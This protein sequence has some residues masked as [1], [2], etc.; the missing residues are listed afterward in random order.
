MRSRIPATLCA[1]ALVVAACSAQPSPTTLPPSSTS[2]T[3]TLTTPS[4]TTTPLPEVLVAEVS[5][6]VDAPITSLNPFSDD[7]GRFVPGNLVW[8]VVYDID[9]ATWTKV[10]DVVVALPSRSGG[11][12]VNDD[13]TMTVRYEIVDG[14]VWSDGVPITGDD[15]AFTAEV[16]RDLAERGVGTVDPVMATLLEATAEGRVATLTF[17]EPTLVVEDALWVVV[18]SHA[19][20]GA[21]P[22]ETLDAAAW[23]S[24]G[25]FVVDGFE[26]AGGVRF[27]RNEAYWK[28]D[29][30]GR[31]LPYLEAVT[32]EAPDP[33][34]P[35][36][37]VPGFV[38]RD[39]DVASV[40]PTAGDVDRMADAVARG[41]V[42]HRVRTPIIEQLTFDFSDERFTVNPNSVNEFVEFRRAVAG[43]IDPVRLL[44]DADVPWLPEA[45]GLLVPVGESAWS[46]Y[47]N[48][49]SARPELP[50]GA[51]TVLTTTGNAAERPRI[52]EALASVFAE[53]GV[54]YASRL[55]DSQVFF[56]QTLVEGT[57]DLGLWAWVAADGTYRGRLGL[58]ERLDPATSPPAGNYGRWGSGATDTEGARRFSE[59][60]AEARST[61]D[62]DRFDEL[63]HEAEAILATELPLIPLFSRGSGLAVW[64]DRITGVVH[65]GSRS[66]FTWNVER[67]RKG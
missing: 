55:E 33:V 38:L 19:L 27:V 15:V 42:F 14:A 67:W 29:D 24:G 53:L 1:L 6:G 52:A 48:A 21:G 47:R 34:E 58:M 65:N 50:P 63:V 30:D 10:P 40:A 64:P 39:Y 2:T 62:P 20:E 9:P 51:A 22:I 28:T 41:A 3:T 61:V 36:S 12:T 37:P 57:Y 43:A 13:G 54:A 35:M 8:A 46:R 49:P 25:P 56:Q 16:M 11:I 23:P 59:I 44:D 18:P 32:I 17:A 31:R 7:P 5:I 45:S 4:T 60:V 66:G 26:P